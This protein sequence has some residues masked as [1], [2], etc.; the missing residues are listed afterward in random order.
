MG[1]VE[2]TRRVTVSSNAV[3]AM[4]AIRG[5]GNIPLYA[6]VLEGGESLLESGRRTKNAAA[7]IAALNQ[8]SRL[9]LELVRLSTGSSSD[10]VTLLLNMSS[11][12]LVE[13][14]KSLGLNWIWDK[15]IA[16]AMPSDASSTAA[17]PVT[18]APA[19]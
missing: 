10:V 15:M 8:C 3:A 6:A 7:A 18:A 16:A 14:S 17:E 13:T 19:E 11:A 2:A 1:V 9:E 12:E 5:S 4:Q